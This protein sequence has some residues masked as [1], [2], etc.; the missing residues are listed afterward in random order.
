MAALRYDGLDDGNFHVP[1][2]TL[3]LLLF[4][5]LPLLVFS[6]LLCLYLRWICLR[7]GAG[8]HPVNALPAAAATGLDERTINSFPV[9]LSL[10]GEEAAQ[11]SI[12]LSGVPAGEK[13]KALPGCGHGFHVECVD[14]WLRV[15]ASCPLCRA[16][17]RGSPAGLALQI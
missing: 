3:R 13:V 7:R 11:C 9:R 4:I 17:P 5:S 6:V 2:T 12:C 10:A 15:H 14:E 1:G 8:T 16:T